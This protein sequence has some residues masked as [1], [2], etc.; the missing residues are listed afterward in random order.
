MNADELKNSVDLHNFVVSYEYEGVR[1]AKAIQNVFCEHF[2][3]PSWIVQSI[4]VHSEELVNLNILT[5]QPHEHYDR[6]E[7]K[8]SLNNYQVDVKV[9]DKKTV[10]FN[11]RQ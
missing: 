11:P 5:T 8:Q 6:S 1:Q 9:I 10:K 3:M 2:M 4:L 7:L